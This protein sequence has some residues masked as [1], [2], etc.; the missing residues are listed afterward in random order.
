MSDLNQ[1]IYSGLLAAGASLVLLGCVTT[2][3][4]NPLYMGSNGGQPSGYYPSTYSS[5]AYP[6]APV[7]VT[8]DQ[9]ALLAAEQQ[10]TELERQI[11]EQRLRKL[12][13]QNKQLNQQ[14]KENDPEYQAR[15]ARKAE[16]ERQEREAREERKRLK[17]QQKDQNASTTPL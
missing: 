9:Q 7:Y 13:L 17:Q 8:N 16:K 3:S 1:K 11:Q 4:S 10:N 15:Q 6:S 12:Q 14:I 2:D 5:S